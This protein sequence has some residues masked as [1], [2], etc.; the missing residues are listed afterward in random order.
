NAERFGFPSLYP[1]IA[2]GFFRATTPWPRIKKI[3]P[4]L[5][6]EFGPDQY[7]SVVISHGYVDTVR[8]SDGR[9]HGKNMRDVSRC[10]VSR[11]FSRRR[12]SS[13]RNAQIRIFSREPFIKMPYLL[14]HIRILDRS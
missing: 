9:A 1:G 3:V 11:E 2:P 4:R 5:A 7:Y 10:Q 14:A 12:E 8:R 13:K 6:Q